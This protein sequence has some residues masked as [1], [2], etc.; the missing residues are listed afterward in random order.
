MPRI[1]FR[2]IMSKSIYDIIKR[3]NGEA[4]AKAIRRFDSGIFDISNLP[5]IVKFAGRDALPLLPFLE[6]LKLNSITE[7]K[8]DKNPFQL[9]EAAG[10]DAFYVD[11][12]EKQNSIKPYFVEDE[13]LCTFWDENRYQ[14][15][16]IIHAIKKGAKNLNRTDFLGHE[17][18][19]DAYGT[20]VISIQILKEGGFISIKNRYNHAVENPDNTFGSNP[21]NIIKGLSYALKKYFDVDFRF[22]DSVL[23]DDYTFQNGQVFKFIDEINNVYYGAD[24]YLKNGVATPINKDYQLMVNG[25][26]LDFKDKKLLNV[27]NDY[28][29]LFPILCDELKE[30]VLSVQKKEGKTF[31]FVDDKELM[32][33]Q[34]GVM[35]KLSLYKTK[36]LDDFLIGD[37]DL[38]E[39][40]GFSV[41]EVNRNSFVNC[42]SLKKVVLPS[43]E[44]ISET[45]FKRSNCSVCA[46]KMEEN[47]FYFLGNGIAFVPDLK[48][49]YLRGNLD[50]RIYTFLNKQMANYKHFKVQKEDLGHLILADEKPF[51]RFKNN[52]LTGIYLTKGCPELEYG[53][54]SQLDELEEFSSIE[55]KVVGHHNFSECP[56]LKK[57]SL[58]QVEFIMFSSFQFLEALEE[59]DLSNYWIHEKDA[60]MLFFR[61][62]SLKRILAASLEVND[63][64]EYPYLKGVS[65]GRFN[66]LEKIEVKNGT[67]VPKSSHKVGQKMVYDNLI[68]IKKERGARE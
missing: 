65:L 9:L 42:G 56:K 61:C 8:T 7:V 52:K 6:S 1:F 63:K 10:Y 30:G 46:P 55:T 59:V 64:V 32:A 14:D 2:S 19:E 40:Y 34:D 18:R 5:E 50:T 22:N 38:E 25:F 53:V 68:F 4:F 39:F 36:K 62:P 12:L 20:S 45:A 13:A 47:G 48:L 33:V 31:V 26:L 49:F 37:F 24:F 15:Y 51:L 57:I 66:N 58:P 23:N 29:S 35:K 3:Q 27:T 43:C 41:K 54:I 28:S 16:H 21:D 17:E 11:S 44:K 67:I 60:Q